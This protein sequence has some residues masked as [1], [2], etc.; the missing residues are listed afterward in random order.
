MALVLVD[1]D[2]QV[3][4][5][6]AASRWMMLRWVLARC[7]PSCCRARV[8]AELLAFDV[9]LVDDDSLMSGLVASVRCSCPIRV[10]LRWHHVVLDLNSN[11][12]V[13]VDVLVVVVDAANHAKP[14]VVAS[15]FLSMLISMA[16]SMVLPHS[17]LSTLLSTFLLLY[18][19]SAM[20]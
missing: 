20:L 1:A 7:P 19:F 11:P 14:D 12:S 5:H 18:S 13:D 4:M 16:L 10:Q 8:A 6:Q 9:G 3:E 15:C 17:I 2:D